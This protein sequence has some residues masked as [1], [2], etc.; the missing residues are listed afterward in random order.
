MSSRICQHYN[1]KT[2]YKL[3]SKII[4]KSAQDIVRKYIKLTYHN[5]STQKIATQLKKTSTK[6]ITTK[7]SRQ[8]KT[9]NINQQVYSNL[10]LIIAPG[11]SFQ[12]GYNRI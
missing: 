5:K 12:T 4:Y 1:K 9:K 3:N 2:Q 6:Y 8:H 10:N 11:W 7:L